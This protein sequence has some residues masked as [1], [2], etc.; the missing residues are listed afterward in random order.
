MKYTV[1][2]DKLVVKAMQALDKQTA[3]RI[4]ARLAELA[5]DPYALR[6][7]KPLKMLPGRRSSRVGDWRIIYRVEEESRTIMITAVKSREKAYK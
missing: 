2:V 3:R 4:Y 5:D 7:S 1:K 6:L